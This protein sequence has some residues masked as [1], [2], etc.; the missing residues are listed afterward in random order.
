[1][2]ILLSWCL[3]CW[4]EWEGHRVGLSDQDLYNPVWRFLF[5]LLCENAHLKEPPGTKTFA[6]FYKRLQALDEEFCPTRLVGHP[7][8]MNIHWAPL[9][10]RSFSK[11]YNLVFGRCGKI[12]LC[13]R[14]MQNDLTVNHFRCLY[15]STP[16]RVIAK[17][18]TFQ[19]DLQ[20]VVQYMSWYLPLPS[21]HYLCLFL[22]PESKPIQRKSKNCIHIWVF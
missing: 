18:E 21:C 16:Y 14:K 12:S 1:M 5:Q 15:C 8:C 11:S 20:W 19:N 10:N 13:Q 3:D 9:Q 17:F 2:R 7:C 6:N 4:L 22:N